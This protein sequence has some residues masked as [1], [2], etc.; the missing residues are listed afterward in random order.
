M[1]LALVGS[2]LHPDPLTRPW[3]WLCAGV[4]AD[5]GLLAV[6]PNLAITAH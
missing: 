1:S 6:V 4:L 3:R 5:L 2:F